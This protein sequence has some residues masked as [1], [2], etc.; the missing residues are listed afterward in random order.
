MAVTTKQLA[1]RAGVTNRRIRQLCAQGIIQ[2]EKP[3]RDWLIP[4]EEAGRWLRER[5]GKREDLETKRL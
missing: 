3:G 2:A 1:Q 4:D 5:E